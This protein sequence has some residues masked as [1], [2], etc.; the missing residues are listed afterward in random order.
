MPEPEGTPASKKSYQQKIVKIVDDI[1]SL[2]LIE[3]A[4][5]V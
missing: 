4:G 3:V 5:K 2:T 1:S